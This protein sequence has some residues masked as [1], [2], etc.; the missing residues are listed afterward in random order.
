MSKQNK[1]PFV[2]LYGQLLQ[3]R[4]ESARVAHHPVVKTAQLDLK[5][6][7]ILLLLH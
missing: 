5:Y 7:F 2:H 1:T 6:N 3:I 4:T